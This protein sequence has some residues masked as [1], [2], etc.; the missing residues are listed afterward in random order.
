M[1]RFGTSKRVEL[2]K[3]DV[4]GPGAYKLQSSVGGDLPAYLNATSMEFKYV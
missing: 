3:S 1:D 4:P 2:A